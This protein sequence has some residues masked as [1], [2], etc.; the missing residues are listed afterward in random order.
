MSVLPSVR[1]ALQDALVLALHP[2][3]TGPVEIN[4]LMPADLDPAWAARRACE[5]VDE[6]FSTIKIKVCCWRRLR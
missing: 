3:A 6:G 5:L 2:P 1:C 4:A